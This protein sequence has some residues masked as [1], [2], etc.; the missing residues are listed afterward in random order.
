MVRAAREANV[1]YI[2]EPKVA[3][4]DKL[5]FSEE[6]AGP[7][8]RLIPHIPAGQS[9][10]LGQAKLIEDLL[11]RVPGRKIGWFYTPLALRFL[12]HLSQKSRRGFA[13]PAPGRFD[14]TVYDC[15]DDLAGFEGADPEMRALEDRLLGLAD[16]VF[17]GGRSLYERLAPRRADVHLEPSSVDVAHFAQARSWSHAPPSDQAAIPGPRLGWFGVIDERMNLA[18]LAQAADLRPAWNFIM[19]GPTAKIDAASLPQRRNIHWLGPKDYQ[20]LPG[21]LAGWD[22]GI[23]PFALNAATAH[24][25]PTKTPEYLAAGTPVV[26]T[27]VRDVVSPWGKAGLVAIARN[28]LEFVEAAQTVMSRPRQPW[29]GAVDAALADLSWD[30]TWARMAKALATVERAAPTRRSVA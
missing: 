29:L 20:A 6:A 15:M 27:P 13:A 10:I 4:A 2:E 24:I 22:C 9:P 17:T 30:R 25:S 21:Y 11:R 7:I 3:E 16:V 28:A 19:L 14:V 8:R 26:S 23:M 5:Y 12:T 1:L 18:L